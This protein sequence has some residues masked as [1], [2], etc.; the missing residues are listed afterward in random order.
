MRHLSNL[1]PPPPDHAKTHVKTPFL[2]FVVSV[3]L[4]I[5]VRFTACSL[6]TAHLP[7]PNSLSSVVYMYITCEMRRAFQTVR[8]FQIGPVILPQAIYKL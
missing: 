7:R 5:E 4:C 1:P 3:F 8:V 2:S 6:V